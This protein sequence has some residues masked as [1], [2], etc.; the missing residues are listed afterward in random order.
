L[1][2]QLRHPA[3]L[4][5]ALASLDVVSRGRLV[6][7]MGAGWFEPEYLAAGVPFERPAVRV[8]QLDEAVQI[9]TGLL[10]GEPLAFDG[11]HY[12]AAGARVPSPV[13]RPRPPVWV[14]AR[15]DRALETAAAHADGWNMRGWD[16]APDEY[17]ERLSFFE[18]A[19]E[20][21]GR[22]PAAVTRSA[23]QRAT[24]S[25]PEMRA[26]LREWRDLGVSTL[27]MGLGAL[28]FSLNKTGDI[29]RMAS[30]RP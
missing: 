16:V 27:I 8:Q 20:R 26:R 25:V 21:A 29:E 30:A 15:G 19:C 11:R 1:C 9:V 7:G 4:T 18:A 22:E 13:Q 10:R 28:P 3:V 2:A 17:R 14:G 6:V 12:R 5:K 24:N 23:N